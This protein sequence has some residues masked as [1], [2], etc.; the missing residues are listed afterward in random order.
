[1]GLQSSG[2][3]TFLNTQYNLRFAVAAGRCTKG[4]FMLPVI[5]NEEL[6]KSFKD[7][8]LHF[9]LLF[10]TEGLR[11][12]ELGISQENRSKDGEMATACIG[13]ADVTAI[14]SMNFQNSEL[15]E[16]LSIV[17]NMIL[18]YKKDNTDKDIDAFDV[19]AIFINQGVSDSQYKA[20]HAGISKR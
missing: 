6:R 11:A 3:S 5:L 12:Q 19:S 14:N 18:R 1:M 2:K 16:I 7:D 17:V 20:I 8:N 4:I 15:F 13:I 9:M 10:D